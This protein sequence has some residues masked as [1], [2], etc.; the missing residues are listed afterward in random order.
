MHLE[1]KQF[2][3][4]CAC[5]FKF[6]VRSWNI[7]TFGNIKDKNNNNLFHELNKVQRR[8]M[9][10]DII[11]GTTNTNGNNTLTTMIIYKLKL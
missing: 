1:F 10:K 7:S 9:N 6:L 11:N 5:T 2:V 8:I 3:R 4:A